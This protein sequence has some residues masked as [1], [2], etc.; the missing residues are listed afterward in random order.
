MAKMTLT[1]DDIRCSVCNDTLKMSLTCDFTPIG[2]SI[3]IFPC[4]TCLRKAEMKAMK[5]INN[6][7]DEID[8]SKA[9]KEG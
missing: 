8:K 3:Y 2:E 6:L 1:I 5:F 9:K 7:H 4:K